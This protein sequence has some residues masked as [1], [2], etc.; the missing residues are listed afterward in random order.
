MRIAN[1]RNSANEF[2]YTH[3]ARWQFKMCVIRGNIT[4]G[5]FKKDSV[6]LFLR[7]FGTDLSSMQLR[8]SQA[9]TTSGAKIR[10]RMP[11][12]RALREFA[13]KLEAIRG[14][15]SGEQYVVLD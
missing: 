11:H 5:A 12:R 1:E 6:S 15:R 13:Y 14:M 3:V 8:M 2:G 9:H 7:A 4:L 10:A